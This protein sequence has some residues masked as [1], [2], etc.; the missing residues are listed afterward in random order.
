MAAAYLPRSQ[1]QLSNGSIGPEN[2]QN[3]ENRYDRSIL[4]AAFACDARI[5]PVLAGLR[6]RHRNLLKWLSSLPR[7][8]PKLHKITQPH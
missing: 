4:G 1:D 3:R 7:S 6:F 2:R 8:S 5:F